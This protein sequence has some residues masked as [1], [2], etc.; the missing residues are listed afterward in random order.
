TVFSLDGEA[1]SQENDQL[2]RLFGEQALEIA[3]L[4]DLVISRGKEADF[5]KAKAGMIKAFEDAG[6]DL[7]NKKSWLFKI[8]GS[9]RVLGFSTKFISIGTLGLLT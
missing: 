2:K 4:R 8:G 1:L 5:F 7:A 6:E 9:R 3:I